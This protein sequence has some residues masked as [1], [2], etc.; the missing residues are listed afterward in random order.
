MKLITAIIPLLIFSII[1][2]AQGIKGKIIDDQNQPVAYT[3][4]YVPALKTGT[5]SNIEGQF[6]LKLPEGNWEILFQYIGYKTFTQNYDIVKNTVGVSV[7]LQPQS[8]KIKEVKVLASGE[9]PAYYVMRHAI[10]MAPYY[11]NQVAEYDCKLYLKG[12]GVIN[13]IPRLFK[14]RME[15]EGVKKDKPFVLESLNKIHFELPD[16]L[17]QEV[18]AMRSTGDDRDTNPM[19]MITTNLYNVSDYGITSP[20][21]RNA[22]KVYR[23]E[24]AGVFE[25]QG[26]LINKIKVIPKTKGKGTFEG[27]LNVVEGS[28]NIHSADLDFSMPFTNVTMRQLYSMIESNTWM[29]TSLNFEMDLS[30]FGFGMKYNYVTSFSEYKVKL[31]D[32]LDHSFLQKLNQ[33]NQEEAGIMD[34]ISQNEIVNTKSIPASKTKQK[35]N[36]LL[37]KD[38]LSTREMYKLERLM[39]KDIKRTLPTEPLEIPERVKTGKNAIKNDSAYWAEV[40]PIPLINSEAIEFGKKDSITIVHNTP[41]YKDSIRDI[42]VKFRIKDLIVGR[43]YRYEKDSARFQS[44]FSI[45]GI[46]YTEGLTFNTVDGFNYTIP[47]SYSLSDTLGKRFYANAEIGYAFA[48]ED[49]NGNLSFQYFY[50]GIKRQWVSL[51]AG[52]QLED[53]KKGQAISSMENDIYTLF[54]ENN[55]QKFYDNRFL[56][57]N[58]GTEISN[59]LLLK[60][61]LQISSRKQ[62]ANHSDYKFIDYK[63]KEYTPN[64]PNISSLEN[65]QLANNNATIGTV[66]LTYTPQQR[67]RVR[68]NIKYPANSKFPTFKLL[69]EKGFNSFIGS[70]VDFDFVSFSVNQNLNVGFDDYL[71]YSM[72]AGKFLNKKT[73]YASDF[74]FFKSNNQELLFSNTL[75]QFYLTNYYELSSQKQ[76]VEGH[77]S[78]NMDKFL[79]KRLPFIKGTMI[80]EKLKLNYL[81]TEST[82]NYIEL[83]YGLEDIFLMIDIEFISSFKNWEYQSSGFRL[84]I[85]LN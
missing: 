65:W 47:F 46:I 41:E 69:F 17:D 84:C 64:Y 35:I 44:N 51:S 81:T 52:K 59:G 5:T 29:P 53:F 85:N 77:A 70:N 31:N 15:K 45:P 56:T 54:I 10:A 43:R 18:I 3:N 39:D 37:E 28:W 4:I 23:F 20:V 61:G 32:Q 30:A 12:T 27:I 34:S 8:I 48:R 21:G 80:R 82:S 33:T 62:V 58:W 2:S 73:L 68:N 22:L 63:N 83:N 6:E 71:S 78:L 19:T 36:S 38:N 66:E 14:K 40:R 24:L 75:N 57:F 13:K 42:N 50:N 26:K 11:T 7:V 25:D 9:D 67:Y 60:T 74:K 1:S 76:Y 72:E 16:H 55:F 49:F 79:I